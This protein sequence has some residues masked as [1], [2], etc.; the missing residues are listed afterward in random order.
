M[1]KAPCCDK[2]GVRRGAWTPEEDEALV[3]Y[4]KKHGH[5]SWRSLPKH[6]VYNFFKGLDIENSEFALEEIP[7]TMC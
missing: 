4:I 3:E 5:G 2:H 7:I 6:A 1:G